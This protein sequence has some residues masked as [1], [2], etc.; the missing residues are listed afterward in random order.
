MNPEQLENLTKMAGEIEKKLSAIENKQIKSE[1]LKAEVDKIGAEQ[2][3]LE[4]CLICN[5]LPLL[6]A[7]K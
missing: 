2:L 6:K 1:E 5:R 4:R 7:E 3:K